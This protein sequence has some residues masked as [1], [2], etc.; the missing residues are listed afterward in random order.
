VTMVRGPVDST[1]RVCVEHPPNINN[2]NT[3]KRSEEYVGF[4]I[5]VLSNHWY[6]KSLTTVNMTQNLKMTLYT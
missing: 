3:G 5:L 4:I 6:C 2:A 1:Y